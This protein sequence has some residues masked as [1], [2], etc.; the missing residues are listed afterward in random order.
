MVAF[1][2]FTGA[3]RGEMLGALASDVDLG[4][5]VVVIR[6]KKRIKGKR[7]T[8]SAPLTPKRAQILKDW[9]AVRPGVRTSSARSKGWRGAGRSARGRRR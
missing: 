7:S 6:E 8:R 1:A 2:A 3:R 9:S 4:A 5:N